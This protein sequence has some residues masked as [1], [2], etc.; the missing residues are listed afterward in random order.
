M[1]E[2]PTPR[3]PALQTGINVLDTDKRM[4]GSFQSLVLNHVVTYGGNVVWVDSQGHASTH[5]MN[6]I[7]PQGNMLDRINVA[8]AF[9]AFQHY[10]LVENLVYEVNRET[11]IVVLPAID[12][13]Y[14]ADDLLQDEGREMLDEVMDMVQDV[15]Q[16]YR[17]PVLLSTA[18]ALSAQ[19]CAP[20]RNSH[21]HRIAC[22]VT[23][24]GP[25]FMTDSFQTLVYPENGV[26]QTTL[27]F[28]EPVMQ[29]RYNAVKRQTPQKVD[30]HG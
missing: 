11:T 21:Y 14:A 24:H 29:E 7:A 16:R 19:H 1:S 25:R 6:R 26:I 5:V 8:R 20:I 22:E 17:V 12:H 18:A 2:Y 13:F 9:T 23:Q 10:S 28:W 4:T 3:L 27:A 15:I 30:L